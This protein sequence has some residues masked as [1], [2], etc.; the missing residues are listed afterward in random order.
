VFEKFSRDLDGANLQGG[1]SIG[2]HKNPFIR[3]HGD[4]EG[5]ER[6]N[7][8]KKIYNGTQMNADKD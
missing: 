6:Q 5:T 8:N 7:G 3:S 1:P 2:S 4:T